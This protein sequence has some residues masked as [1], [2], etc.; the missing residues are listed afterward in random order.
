MRWGGQMRYAP[1]HPRAG[2]LATYSVGQHS[3]LVYEL[4]TELGGNVVERALALYHDLHESKPPGDVQRPVIVGDGHGVAELRMMS[5]MAAICHRHALRLPYD[6][7]AIVRHADDVM[8]ATERR[9]LIAWETASRRWLAHRREPGSSRRGMPTTPRTRSCGATRRSRTS[10]RPWAWGTWAP[11]CISASTGRFTT[12]T[13][14][15]LRK[16]RF[17]R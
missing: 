13:A 14:Q 12:T 3:C 11:G 6:L 1:S 15:A 2:K 5:R 9:D 16:Q 8:L 4:V 7:P 17:R 10:F